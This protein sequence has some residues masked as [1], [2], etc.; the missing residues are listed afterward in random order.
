MIITATPFRIS[1]F[2]GGTD[3]PAWFKRNGGAVLSV[4]IN[5]YCYLQC[6]NLPPFFAYKNRVV[7]SRIETTR[8][9]DSIEHPCVRAAFRHLGFT[10]GLEVHHFG[11][12]P[13]RTGLGSSSSFA[14]GLLHA[15]YSLRGEIVSKRRL[16]DEAI[17]L[18]QTLLKENV[19]VQDQIAAAF[20]GFNRIDI[21]HNGHFEVQPILMSDARRQDFEEHMILLF[22]G[23]ARHASEVAKKQIDALPEKEG[24]V[25]RMQ[26][27]VDE[28][29]RVLGNG[30]DF[31]E[32][33]EL[34]DE[35]WTLKRSISDAIS[36]AT[37]DEIYERAKRAGAIGGKLLGAG[38]GGFML[39]FVDP[40]RRAHVSETLAGYLQIP[41]RFERSG[42]RIVLFEP[43]A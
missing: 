4:T 5:K 40:A 32:F 26:A 34:L 9:V 10:Q 38:G 6:R 23:I 36:T 37:V 13:A 30:G 20:G 8:D 19:G 14:V 27:L 43:D 29:V 41:F 17:Y 22:T 1:F 15:L 18:E 12:L 33:G 28:G 39:V 2:G 7:W 31:R 25:R 16:A 42:S 11:D 24:V 35:T 3:Y 21:G